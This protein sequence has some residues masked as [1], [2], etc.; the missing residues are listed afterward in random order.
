MVREGHTH[1]HTRRK[2]SYRLV[3]WPDGHNSPYR[4]GWSQDPPPTV[5]P[6]V[7][8]LGH[9]MELS[10]E[11]QQGLWSEVEWGC[12]SLRSQFYPLHHS[13]GLCPLNFAAAFDWKIFLWTFMTLRHHSLQN[14]VVHAF[15]PSVSTEQSPRTVCIFLCLG[16]LSLTPRRLQK[17]SCCLWG[18]NTSPE[19][20]SCQASDTSFPGVCSALAAICRSA[21]EN[22]LCIM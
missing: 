6:V 3:Q 15:W 2:G 10:Q 22:I 13:T 11:R 5:R 4:V 12:Q 21:T 7:R 14:M 16:F 17:S 20:V 9:P 18:A 8:A 19:Y 1:T